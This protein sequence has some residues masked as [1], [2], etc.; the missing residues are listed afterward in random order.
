MLLLFPFY[1]MKKLNT[2][3]L[4]NFLILH[5]YL[6]AGLGFEQTLVLALLITTQVWAPYYGSMGSCHV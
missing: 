4:S 3:S 1:K 6:V 5:N 2:E